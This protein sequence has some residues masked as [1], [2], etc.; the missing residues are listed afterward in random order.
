[1]IEKAL[2]ELDRFR[3]ENYHAPTEL[4]MTT[5][6][7]IMLATELGLKEPDDGWVFRGAMIFG[8]PVVID[9]RIAQATVQPGPIRTESI[10]IVHQFDSQTVS[11]PPSTERTYDDS[12]PAGR[13]AAHE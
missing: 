4:R 11:T 3:R 5:L 9:G 12:K 10:S 13:R 6:T 1:M 2:G 7:A 8:L